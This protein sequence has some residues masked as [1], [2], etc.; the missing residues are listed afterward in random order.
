M[1]AVK[2]TVVAELYEIELHLKVWGFFFNV[3]RPHH[4][5]LFSYSSTFLT[6]SMQQFLFALSLLRKDML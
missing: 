5:L 3:Y 1:S 6:Q 2:T 4:V